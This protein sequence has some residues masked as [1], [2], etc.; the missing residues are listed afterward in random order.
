[1]PVRCLINPCVFFSLERVLNE[2]E[3]TKR[4]LLSF[5]IQ[6]KITNWDGQKSYLFIYLSIYFCM[7]QS[8]SPPGVNLNFKLTIRS[9]PPSWDCRKCRLHL[10]WEVRPSL[11]SVLGITLNCIWWW[12]TDLGA[13][14]NDEYLVIAIT[15]W[16]GIVVL[17]RVSSVGRMELFNH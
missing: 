8:F 4:K 14:E 1:M 13:L 5:F 3:A 2:L 15:P 11:M 9:H 10:C 6:Y 12:G 7:S 16:S 17:V